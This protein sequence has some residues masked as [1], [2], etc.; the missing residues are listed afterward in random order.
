[1]YSTEVY[2]RLPIKTIIKMR[3]NSLIKKELNKNP[4]KKLLNKKFASQKT[5]QYSSKINWDRIFNNLILTSRAIPKN[6]KVLEVGSGFGH[7]L[8]I[9]SDFRKDLDIVGIDSRPKDTWGR[10]NK[11]GYK[12]KEMD[13]LNL[14]FKKNSFD[15]IIS[16]GVMEHTYDE[17]KFMKE[18]NRVLKP[19]GKMIMFNLP[20]KYSTTEF[21]ARNMKMHHH[22]NLYSKKEVHGLYEKYGFK[23][24]R[25]KSDYLIPGQFNYISVALNKF[26]D[27]FAVAINNFD[28]FLCKTPLKIFAQSFSIISKKK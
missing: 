7:N 1:M 24:I 9:L 18:M 6:S 15:A 27:N 23:I 16:Y 21:I 26:L 17:D 25:I 28:T 2:L 13:A 14:K 20:N 10:L 5:N 8:V 22:D 19:K 11:Q 3:K 4:I 12:I